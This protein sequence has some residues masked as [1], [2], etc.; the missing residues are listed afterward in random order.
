MTSILLLVG[1]LVLSQGEVSPVSVPPNIQALLD[2]LHY[3]EAEQAVLEQL[4]SQPKWEIGH[5]VLAK[6][7][8]VTG[9]YDLAEQSALSA[10]HLRESLD[11]FMLLAV[12][13]MNSRKLSESI[14]WLEKAAKER[15]DYFEIYK[16]LGLDLALNGK[17]EESERAFRRSIELEPKNWELYYLQG[18]T[19][20]ELNKLEDSQKALY[21]ATELNPSSAKSWTALG[22]VQER[23]HSDQ[24]AEESYRKALGLCGAQN[25]DCAWPLLQLG[26]LIER[27]KGAREAE[28]YFRQAVTARPD[29]ARARFFLG[30]SLAAH[31][32][33][34]GARIELE[35]AVKLDE[36]KSQY[37]YQL[38]QV[39]QRLK[40]ELKAKQHLERY[41][42]LASLESQK[43]PSIEL[44]TP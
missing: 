14:G 31:G 26:F 19:L 42:V 2:G 36:N 33:F 15:S 4:S 7:Y 11:G 17:M 29:W 28:S 44:I 22:Q 32:D 12:A 38:A 5:L 39:Y 6:I 9:R 25:S 20:Q 43:R 35:A 13:T 1:C 37:H 16:L 3:S 27:Q 23:L 10:I 21:K 34:R 41:R 24:L 30:K 18:R 40:E 8:N